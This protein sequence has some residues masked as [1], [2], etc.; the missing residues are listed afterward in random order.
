VLAG[1][2]LYI[3]CALE[4]HKLENIAHGGAG[5]WLPAPAEL[6][7]SPNVMA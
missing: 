2:V 4:G 3:H 7:F 6:L 5:G 1:D